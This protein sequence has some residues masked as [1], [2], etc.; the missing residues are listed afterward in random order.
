[1]ENESNEPTQSILGASN[2]AVNAKLPNVFERRKRIMMLCDLSGSMIWKV[3]QYWC[4]TQGSYTTGPSKF[5]DF[6]RTFQDHIYKIPGPGIARKLKQS[7]QTN[8]LCS[9]FA[10]FLQEQIKS[11]NSND[12]YCCFSYLNHVGKA[13]LKQILTEQ[14]STDSNNELNFN[15]S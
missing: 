14:L 15:V 10:K 1:M 7:K 5:Q 13:Q 2:H 4:C 6:S 11:S 9:L 12:L 3:T 8:K